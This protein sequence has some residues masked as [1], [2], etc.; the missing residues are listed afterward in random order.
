M[1][2]YRI[3]ATDLRRQ[4]YGDRFTAQGVKQRSR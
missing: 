4:I 3:A 2:A 1:P